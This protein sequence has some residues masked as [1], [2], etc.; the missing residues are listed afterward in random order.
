METENIDE[1]K[2][3]YEK[4]VS[5]IEDSSEKPVSEAQRDFRFWSRYSDQHQGDS[6]EL[7]YGR[8]RRAA[9]RCELGAV[10]DRMLK[11][12]LPIGTRHQELQKNLLV[13]AEKKRSLEDVLA[14]C[15]VFE[16][17][18]KNARIVTDKSHTTREIAIFNEYEFNDAENEERIAGLGGS[19]RACGRSH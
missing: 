8:A 16:A 11:S 4:I 7:F 17:G 15:R 13:E 18:E 6:F 3:T 10:H 12:R 14:I 1:D 2:D 9:L 19:C 5:G